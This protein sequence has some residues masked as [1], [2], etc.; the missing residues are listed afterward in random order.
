[1]NATRLED[2]EELPLLSRFVQWVEE[3]AD[4]EEVEKCLCRCLGS[5]AVWVKEALAAS[6][7]FEAD[8]EL[9]VWEHILFVGLEA[10][11]LLD[12]GSLLNDEK[13]FC[14]V[15]PLPFVFSTK[16]TMEQIEAKVA[17][18]NLQIQG[19]E[20]S[21]SKKKQQSPVQTCAKKAKVKKD[22]GATSAIAIFAKAATDGPSPQH[23]TAWVDTLKT[24]ILHPFNLLAALQRNSSCTDVVTIAA[25]RLALHLAWTEKVPNVEVKQRW[26][27]L[28]K[29][30]VEMI[31]SSHP[32]AFTPAALQCTS[33]GKVVLV[34][35]AQSL[36]HFMKTFSNSDDASIATLLAEESGAHSAQDAAVTAT[37][38]GEPDSALDARSF[39]RMYHD[40]A[41]ILR[42]TQFTNKCK[43]NTAWGYQVL[44]ELKD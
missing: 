16:L 23:E 6:R 24:A 11:F 22:D 26:G 30:I 28:R 2:G 12:E 27:E 5:V 13:G 9:Q 14:G 3:N 20:A 21:T 10:C 43:L 15:P 18:I 37:A 32:L 34:A 8:A 29:H 7:Y 31:I 19:V 44:P 40:Q 42:L 39:A 25:V 36:N 1:M 41:L 4:A 35:G 17:L 33:E 38:A